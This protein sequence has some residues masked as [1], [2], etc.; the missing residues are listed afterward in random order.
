MRLSRVRRG[1][2]LIELLVVVAIIAVLIG[3]LLPA[4]GRARGEARAMQCGNNMRQAAVG[5]TAYTTDNDKYP[6]SYV[7]G[8][9][10]SGLS[11][12][13]SEQLNTN[14]NPGNGYVHWSYFLF[15]AGATPQESFENPAVYNGGAPATNPGPELDDW[16]S[17]Q[18]N[19]LGGSPGA[20]E[21]ED[22][23]VKRV[24]FGGNA[25]L[26]PRNKFNNPI[27]RR[28]NELVNASIVKG[29]ARTILLA[30]FQES[31]QW[32]SIAESAGGNTGLSKSHRSITP[33]IGGTNV[34]DPYAEPKRSGVKSFF[35]PGANEILP[36]DDV[37]GATNLIADDGTAP[38]NAVG[39]QQPGQTA[40]FVFADGH[41]ERKTLRETVAKREWGSRFY[42]ITGPDEVDTEANQI[43]D[44][45]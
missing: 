17:W 8:A 2:T 4:L 12:K 42:S 35:Y 37:V 11:W 1:F 28:S 10:E 15:A 34:N 38:I 41:V 33:F 31:N 26:F 32:L 3:I 22:R 21:P 5:V 14:P 19:D 20:E 7:Y 27:N 16:E 18:L 36:Y 30:E 24:G 9:D 45:D 25:A 39:R 44:F 29:P 13:M 40:N 43:D 23:Q 6:P